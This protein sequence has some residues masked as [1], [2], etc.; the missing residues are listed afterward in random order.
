MSFHYLLPKIGGHTDRGFPPTC[1]M[2]ITV[3]QYLS[4]MQYCVPWCNGNNGVHVEVH[5]G[6]IRHSIMWY[7]IRT[8]MYG[9]AL[10][11]SLHLVTVQYMCRAMYCM[12]IDYTA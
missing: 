5:Y 9:R 7:S 1:T 10:Q 11:T 3:V 4:M 6:V 12:W 2:W 8:C